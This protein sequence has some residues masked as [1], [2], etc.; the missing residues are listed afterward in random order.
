MASKIVARTLTIQKCFAPK[1]MSHFSSKTIIPEDGKLTQDVESFKEPEDPRQKMKSF[2]VSHETKDHFPSLLQDSSTHHALKPVAQDDNKDVTMDADEEMIFLKVMTDIVLSF[3]LTGRTKE[4]H[5]YEAEI[6][7]HFLRGQKMLDDIKGQ[8]VEEEAEN[9]TTKDQAYLIAS[10]DAD[11]E[12]MAGLK[13]DVLKN[14][15]L[16]KDSGGLDEMPGSLVSVPPGLLFKILGMAI[17][18]ELKE[19][20]DGLKGG[21]VAGASRQK[22][23]LVDLLKRVPSLPK[24]IKERLKKVSGLVKALNQAMNFGG[25]FPRDSWS[26]NYDLEG[27]FDIGVKNQDQKKTEVTKKFTK[28]GDLVIKMV[29]CGFKKAHLSLRVEEEL[30]FVMGKCMLDGDLKEI[31]EIVQVNPEHLYDAEKVS[32]ELVDG[33]LKVTFPKGSKDTMASDVFIVKWA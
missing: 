5:E 3:L 24:H 23:A 28:E 17:V 29:A 2:S 8:K 9:K 20:V 10:G 14:A 12:R 19:G 21:A 33:Y 32:G 4:P 30:L 1:V 13:N 22:K 6:V 27:K 18:D 31:D 7:E 26:C 16:K 15:D 25:L 11:Y